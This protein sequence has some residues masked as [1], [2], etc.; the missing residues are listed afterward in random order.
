MVKPTTMSNGQRALWTFL[1]CALV[2][3]FLVGVI[4]LL[5]TVVSGALQ[6][7][8]PSLKMFRTIEYDHGSF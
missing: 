5:I 4:V 8:P 1:M 6:M 7:G 3:P 2:G